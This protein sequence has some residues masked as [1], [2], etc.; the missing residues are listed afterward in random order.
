MLVISV[1]FG[2]SLTPLYAGIFSLFNGW[3]TSTTENTLLYKNSQN[4]ALLVAAL[5]SDPNPSKGGGA[6][7]IVDNLALVADNGP[8][9][10]S[11]NIKSIAKSDQINVY[12]VRE[13]DSLSQIAKMFD[14]T[15]ETI[16]WSN[17]IKSSR[18]IRTGQT[19]VILPVSGVRHTVKKGD[20][21]NSIAKKYNADSAEIASFNEL[22]NIKLAIGDELIIPNGKKKGVILKSKT[23]AV[24]HGTGGPLYIGYYIPPLRTYRKTQG[25]H[26]YNAVDLAAT[27]GSP[28]LASAN[29]NVLISKRGWNGGYGNYIVIGHNNSTQTVYAH[30]LR[31]IVYAGQT[32]V[33]GQVIGYVGSTGRS[34]GPHV[35]F[36]VR[37]ARNPF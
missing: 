29:G 11:S 4:V 5:N 13:G 28:I 20:T 9:T 23:R 14:V 15:T 35:H 26:G 8:H 16:L 18:L 2:V 24:V 19:L 31:N 22:Q 17:D 34:T 36:E 12:V 3:F 25:L 30:T 21:L 1:V 6:I 33:Q 10:S 32:V 37:G 27:T 7:K